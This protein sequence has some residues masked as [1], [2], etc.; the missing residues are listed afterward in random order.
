LKKTLGFAAALAFVAL[1]LLPGPAPAT[2]QCST[3]SGS[4]STMTYTA[5]GMTCQGA[6]DKI[7]NMATDLG[8][9]CT[10]PNDLPCNPMLVVDVKCFT[11]AEGKKQVSGHYVYGCTTCIDVPG[12]G[13]N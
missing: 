4:F 11:N 9:A 6:K 10:G 12:G 7:D 5:M 1:A 13:N 3:C 2:I 8:A